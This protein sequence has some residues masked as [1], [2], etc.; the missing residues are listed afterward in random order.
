MRD[1]ERDGVEWSRKLS[2]TLTRIKFKNV[3]RGNI[4]PP[5]A[6]FANAA[7]VTSF[8]FLFEVSSS[9][10]TKRMAA[11]LFASSCEVTLECACA[12]AAC[13]SAPMEEVAAGECVCVCDGACDGV[14]ACAY[15]ALF[16][17]LLL[18]LW[19]LRPLQSP[20][21]QML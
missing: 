17:R 15:A 1:T 7:A 8:S 12:C 5:L 4:T 13:T 6:H 9:S 18:P 2:Q 16:L 11:E 14:C 10:S 3:N 19:R 21:V 20:R